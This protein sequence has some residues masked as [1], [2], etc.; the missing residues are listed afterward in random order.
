[1]LSETTFKAGGW[2]AT[3]A[4]LGWQFQQLG[5]GIFYRFYHEPSVPKEQG[6]VERIFTLPVIGNVAGRFVRVSDYGQ[7]EK[8]KAVEEKVEKEK[9]RETLKE[10]ELINKY[11]KEAREK[12]IKFST[13]SLEN[14]LV[15]ER[16]DGRP[17]TSTEQADAKRLVQKFRISLKR[18]EADSNTITLIDASS[19]QAKLEIIKEIKDKMSA[20]EFVKYRSQLI[21]DKI[22][23]STVFE[24]LQID[25]R[26]SQ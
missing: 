15:R 21:K 5:G 24:Q 1:V 22:V 26:K 19:N 4:F 20:E 16:Y 8:L 11:I 6:A 13:G 17:K 18:G 7:V 12:N 2:P 25:E 3:K 14:A 10:R 9:A 23:S